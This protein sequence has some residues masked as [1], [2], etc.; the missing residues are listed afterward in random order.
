M[1][2]MYMRGDMTIAITQFA[3]IIPRV[4]DKVAISNRKFEVAEVVWHIDNDTWVEV[5]I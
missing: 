5:Q 1:T 4:K 3:T 2:I